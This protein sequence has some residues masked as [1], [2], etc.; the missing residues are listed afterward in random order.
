V[1]DHPETIEGRWDILYRDYPEVYE[2]FTSFPYEPHVMSVLMAKFPIRDAT[3]LD[4][5]SGTGKSS[6]ALAEH[7]REVVGV[8]PEAAVRAVAERS[9]AAL[10]V[11]NIR[12]LEGDGADIPLPDESVDAAFSITAPIQSLKELLRVLRPGGVIV[13]LDV[14]PHWYGGEL[15]SVIGEEQRPRVSAVI[16]SMIAASPISISRT[17]RSTA[18]RRTSFGHTA[19]SMA[20]RPS[21]IRRGRDR[22]RSVGSGGFTIDTSSHGRSRDCSLSRGRSDVGALVRRV[23]LP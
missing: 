8:E 15:D 13:Y 14:A 9:A 2:A 19:S 23:S 20:E 18:Q 6:F 7:A 1:E 12:F 21:S 22:C 11:R 4:I 16:S 17:S 5:G 3:V 10:G